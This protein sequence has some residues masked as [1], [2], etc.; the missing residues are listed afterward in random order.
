VKKIFTGVFLVLILYILIGSNIG[1]N[2]KIITNISS[3]LP[4]KLS[5]F[6]K[7]NIFIFYYKDQREEKLKKVNNIIEKQNKILK[8]KNQQLK[9]N[10]FIIED[11]FRKNKKQIK[12]TKIDSNL[13]DSNLEKFQTTSI[14]SGVVDMGGGTSFI[15]EYENNIYL[16]SSKGIIS[17][18][19][20][21]EIEENN[22]KFTSIPSNI[23]DV[24]GY[25]DFFD[26]WGV[27]IKSFIIHENKIYISF[28][29]MPNDN[30]YTT[31]II[32]SQLNKNYLNFTDFFRT[33][34][35]IKEKNSYGEFAAIQGGGKIELYKNNEILLSIGDY[36]YRDMAQNEESIFGKIIAINL[37]TRKHRLI[38][39][40]HRNVQGIYYDNKNDLIYM[41]EHGPKG[42]D[43][44]NF[45]NFKNE[46]RKKVPNF[47][48]PISSYGEHYGKANTE[49]NLKKYKKAPLNKSHINFGFIEPLKYFNP[50]I[51]PSTILKIKKNNE[52]KILL[53]SMLEK[54][55]YEFNLDHKN[56]IIDNKI[57]FLGDR[58]RDFIYLEDIKK[59]L[60]FLENSASLG[61][62]SY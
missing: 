4:E 21:S 15:K 49:K 45:L 17:Y 44:I 39:M 57:I 16:V 61:I 12:F 27:G 9:H 41:T 47:G 55:I 8:F 60:I 37:D 58:V 56:N 59:L 52:T 33:N 62:Y 46:D 42:G 22:L 23:V 40:G 14:V 24:I 50:A 6:I 32:V 28:T 48:W 18:L 10:S 1:T 7:E 30:C 11:Q 20:K 53:G 25:Q 54:S 13:S 26:K 3:A 43:E 36:R 51:A 19:Q 34:E 5:Q 2:N 31:S 38:S 29:D 35:C